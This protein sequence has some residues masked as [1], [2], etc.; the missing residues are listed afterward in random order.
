MPRFLANAIDEPGL[1]TSLAENLL[2][3]SRVPSV[4]PPSTTRTSRPIPSVA[5]TDSRHSCMNFTEFNVNTTTERIGGV[6]VVIA[7]L[8]GRPLDL[9]SVLDVGAIFSCMVYIQEV[10]RSRRLALLGIQARYSPE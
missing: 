4:E 7:M 2:T 9:A 1:T 6:R 5:N 8:G 10:C 3:T